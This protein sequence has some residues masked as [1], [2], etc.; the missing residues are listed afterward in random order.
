MAPTEWVKIAGDINITDSSGEI[1]IMPDLD[2]P[3]WVIAAIDQACEGKAAR[4]WAERLLA[5]REEGLKDAADDAKYH[6]QVDDNLTG[7]A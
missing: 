1:E 5:D 6:Q 3:A 4:E 7:R 2:A